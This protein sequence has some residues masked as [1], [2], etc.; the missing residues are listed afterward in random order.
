MLNPFDTYFWTT[1]AL[2]SFFILLLYFKVPALIANSLDERAN[3]IRKELED[4]RKLREEAQKLLADYKERSQ[5]ADKI[6]K[7][8]ITQAENEAKL[9][10][11]EARRALKEEL[12]RRT[13]SLEEKIVRAERQAIEEVRSFAVD[14][15]LSTVE[16]IVQT[17]ITEQE[18]K[19]LIDSGLQELKQ[20]LN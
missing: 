9:A 15:A 10:T 4:A 19:S 8:I 5:N 18:A 14:L 20:R 17:K 12:D 7:E 2:F 3:A 6:A 11:T 1:I 16:K 13:K